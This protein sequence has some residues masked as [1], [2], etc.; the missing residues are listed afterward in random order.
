M[1]IKNLVILIFLVF[2]SC[3][4]HNNNQDV[5]ALIKVIKNDIY[6]DG[7]YL[8]LPVNYCFDCFSEISNEIL[9]LDSAVNITVFI[10]T[11]NSKELVRYKRSYP[12]LTY[13]LSPVENTAYI[14]YP[15][16]LIKEKRGIQKLYI[17]KP[18]D[19]HSAFNQKD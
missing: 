2:Y 11:D 8:M 4:Q 19:I 6:E 3:Y 7:I 14:H 15:V 5:E 9:A 16:L 13:S 17:T 10:R 12:E 18:Q 1:K